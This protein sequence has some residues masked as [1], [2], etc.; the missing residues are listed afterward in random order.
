[1]DKTR[2]DR[3]LTPILAELVTIEAG[4]YQHPTVRQLFNWLVDPQIT[5]EEFT[6]IIGKLAWDVNDIMEEHFPDYMYGHENKMYLCTVAAEAL[7]WRSPVLEGVWEL[8]AWTLVMVIDLWH[9]PEDKVSVDQIS[10]WVLNVIGDSTMCPN[11]SLRY[12]FIILLIKAVELDDCFEKQATEVIF[13]LLLFS[14]H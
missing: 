4:N 5:G 14:Q 2:L 7:A 12:E 3:A 13:F 6:Y 11:P 8:A 10:T 9:D 1:M